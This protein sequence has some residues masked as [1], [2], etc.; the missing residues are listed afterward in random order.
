MAVT[1]SHGELPPNTLNPP[2]V[3]FRIDSVYP[4]AWLL[5]IFEN[6]GELRDVSAGSISLAPDR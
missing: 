2:C 4:V 6:K 5:L 3:C 1:C